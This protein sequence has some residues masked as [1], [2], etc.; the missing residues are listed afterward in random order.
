MLVSL[1]RSAASHT[2]QV[3]AFIFLVTLVLVA[4]LE[5]VGEDALSGFLAGNQG[6]AIVAS[7]LVGL[8]PNCSAS[9]V[10]TQLYLEG[11]LGFGPLIAGLLVSA[12][13]GY[14]VL[15]RTN[16]RPR[17]NAVIILFLF[18]VA[19]VWGLLLGAFGL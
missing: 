3:S 15:F 2:I 7:A 9:V 19:V 8:V 11:V 14:L 10:I 12:G 16:R 4:L 1:V 17:E 18:A 5:A 13:V 6:L